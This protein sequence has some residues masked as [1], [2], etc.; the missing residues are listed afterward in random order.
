M[1]SSGTGLKFSA[2]SSL[3]TTESNLRK[4]FNRDWSG[5][6]LRIAV[7]PRSVGIGL[8]GIVMRGCDPFGNRTPGLNRFKST[9]G[10]VVLG[11]I[12]KFGMRDEVGG[13][14]GFKT[15]GFVIRGV[16]VFGFVPRKL[17]TGLVAGGLRGV[18]V[19]GRVT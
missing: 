3:P 11:R 2:K 18:T 19:I 8:L 16:E 14:R 15:L 7:S 6:M 13:V 4:P 10:S 5:L 17:G 1:L 9:R 12:I